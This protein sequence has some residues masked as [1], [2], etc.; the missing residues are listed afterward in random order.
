MS[1]QSQIDPALLKALKW[2]LIGP[3]RGG[4]VVAVAGDPADPFTFYFGAC[5]GGVWKTSDGGN[6]WE[7]VSDGF[8]NTAPVGALAVAPSDPNVIYAGMGE[9]AIRG[10]VSEGDGVYKSTDGGQTWQHMGLADTRAIGRIRVHPNNPDLVYVA[11]LGHIFGQNE[12]RGVF[13]S[14][15]GGQ[16]WQKVLYKSPK[17][18]AVDLSMDA[19]NPRILYASLWEAQRHPH[20]LISGGPDS[21][22]Y[23]SSDGGDTWQE[24]SHNKGLPQGVLGKIGVAASPARAGRVWALVEAEDGGLFR[25]DDGGNSWQR[26]NDEPDLRQ[27][28]WYYMHIYAD[29]QEADTVYVLNLRV[30]KSV[31]GGKS[32]SGIPTA[33]GDNHDLWIDP[34]NTKRMVEGN[35]GGACVSF[36]GGRSWSTLYNQPTAQFYHVVTDSRTPYF[37]YGAQQDNSTLAGPSRSDAGSI[38]MGEWYPVGG[39]E[40]GYIAVRPDDPDIVYAGSYGGLIT[41][42][43]HRTRQQ[44]NIAAWPENPMGYSAGELKYRFQW[45]YP[46]ILSPHDPNVL[47]VCSQYVHRTSDEGTSWETISPDLTRA[48]QSKMGPSGGPITR[49]NTSVEYYGTIFSFAESPVQRGVLWAGADD[50]LIHVSKDNGQ[51]WQ[52]V[53][54]AANVLP[55]WALISLIEPSPHDAGTAYVAATR[56][57]LDD[58]R[59]YLLKTSD[60]GQNWQAITGGLPEDDFMRAIREDPQRQGLLYAGGEKGLYVSLD[61]GL[62]WQPFRQNLPLVPIHDLAVADGD[63]IAATHGRSFWILDDLAPLR[64]L[65]PGVAGEAAHL[66]APRATVRYRGGGRR[67]GGGESQSERDFQRSGGVSVLTGRTPGG[68]TVLLD[69]GQ[70]PPTGVVVTYY[71]KEAPQGEVTLAFLDAQGKE[72]R[73]FSSEAKDEKGQGKSEGGGGQRRQREPRVPKDAGSNR[74]VWNLRLANATEV[75]G[76]IIWAGNLQ[77]PQVP[78]GKY[79]V[80]L[81]AGGQSYTQPFEVVK[82]PRLPTSQ[83][84]FEEQ[85][86]LLLKIGDKLSQTHAAINEIRELRQQAESWQT[87]AERAEQGKPVAEAAKELTEKLTAI[88]EELIQVKSKAMEDPLNYPIKLNNKLAALAGIVDSADA[89][90]TK[91]SYEVFDHL[92]RGV[93]TL[94]DQLSALRENQVQRFNALVHQTQ[95]PALSTQK[96]A[97]D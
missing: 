46:I 2:R 91:Q 85:Y 94:L 70:N 76:A 37:V 54:P 84:D 14:Q 95:L 90:P 3:F 25:S 19:S 63:L 64:Q 12:E 56:Y 6:V 97:A 65:Q 42:Y 40:S 51:S 31:D 68:E 62:H 52:N 66:F 87:R 86:Q 16:S 57:K 43:D 23:K 78:P 36:N 48:E 81:T 89:A 26:L 27:R 92:A 7:N 15:D 5:D 32:F 71:L 13:R 83:Q 61:D 39:G 45:T 44:R 74:F 60:F 1:V 35:D 88:E 4:R 73:A 67:G 82:D 75:P 9:T 28:P 22:L 10:N 96:A 80:R 18:G 72:L 20:T 50:G 47:Y 30:W 29:P 38:T 11:A 59:P 93:D 69:A 33:H 77:G 34:N 58:L 53:T 55:E 79:Q 41:R 17:A 21:G 49:D 8:F 24:I